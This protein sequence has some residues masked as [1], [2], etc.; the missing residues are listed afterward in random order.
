MLK[1]NT[2][3]V[4]DYINNSVNNNKVLDSVKIS[5]LPVWG[6][7]GT[8]YDQTISVVMDRKDF[9]AMNEHIAIYL[10]NFPRNHDTIYID[11]FH[12]GI[13][14]T[15]LSQRNFFLHY[16]KLQDNKRVL[17]RNTIIKIRFKQ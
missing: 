8:K 13:N 2:Y 6:S 1:K 3:S 11:T 5:Y 17:D 12:K 15:K 10:M 9:L 16:W 7:D 14:L 4:I